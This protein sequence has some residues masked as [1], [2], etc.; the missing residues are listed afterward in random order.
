ML[1]SDIPVRDNSDEVLASWWNI[2]RTAGLASVQAT[3]ITRT[4]TQL[5]AAALTNDIEIYSLA[6][7]QVLLGSIIKS[8]T[9]FAGS[10]ITAYD[11]TLGITGDLD[12]FA[13]SY[14]ALAAVAD[15]NHQF[16]WNPKIESF[17]S[18]GNSATSVR[19][20]ATAVG[21][22]LDQSTDGE[23]EIYLFLTELPTS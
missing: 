2:L 15:S 18:D 16:T 22:N 4:H 8:T 11:L 1:F 14:N 21:A 6:A 13:L 7:N 17:A 10:G 5:Q 9:A 3:K 12:K 19:L 23:V 20:G